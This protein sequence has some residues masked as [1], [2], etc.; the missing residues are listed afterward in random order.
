M[1][2]NNKAAMK[3]L[4]FSG[5]LFFVLI[6]S[7]TNSKRPA[8]APDREAFLSDLKQRT[9]N[10]FWEQVDMP[11]WGIPDRYPSRRFTSIAAT[12]FG[13][14]SY[15]V[16]IENGYITREQGAGRVLNTLR[17]FWHSKQGPE[18]SGVTGYKGFYYHF[19]TYGDGERFENTELSTIDTGLLMAGILSCQS[20]FDGDNT[21]ETSIRALA[22]SLYLRVQWDWA[23]NGLDAMSMGYHP[24]QG[25]LKAKWVGYNEAMVLVLMAMGS[26][27]HPIGDSAWSTWCKPYVWADF[28][29]YDMINFSPLFGHQYSQMYVDFRGIQDAYTRSKGI[30]YFENSRRA[31]LGNRAYCIDNPKAYDGYSDN[32][33]GLTACDGPGHSEQMTDHGLRQFWSYRA[34]GASAIDTIDDGTIAP[35]A[36]GGSIPFAPDECINALMTM[37]AQ[38]GDSLYRKY[39][40]CDAFNMTYKTSSGKK[41]WFDVDYIGID[42]GPILIQLENYQTGLIWDVMKKNKYIVAGLRRAGFSGGW[43]E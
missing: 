1:K 31:T 33:W 29:G 4:L 37:K 43:L 32:I 27:T 17:W 42:Q 28:Y 14:T 19:L 21:E 10:Y 7:C 9:F 22:D 11:T 30:D 2:R 36:A 26:P 8:E 24:G 18:K 23:M 39:G 3:A 6:V 15:L 5:L 20:Y 38:Y 41:G 13:L 25:F 40:F 34:R 35:T 16:G 12:G